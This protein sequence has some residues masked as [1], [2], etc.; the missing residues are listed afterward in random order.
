MRTPPRLTPHDPTTLR[1]E[2]DVLCLQEV[3][4]EVAGDFMRG[5]HALGYLED[6]IVTA[7]CAD[8]HVLPSDQ[9]RRVRA[10]AQL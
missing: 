4:V 3:V 1:Y 7:G 10:D 5:L 2:P 8:V 9:P 6:D